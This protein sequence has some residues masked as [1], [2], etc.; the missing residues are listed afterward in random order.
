MQQRSNNKFSIF[1]FQ[2]SILLLLC[3][4]FAS[5]V[6]AQA[7]CPICVVAIGAG[8]GF[9]RWLGVDDLISSVWIGAVLL[10]LVIWTLYWIRKKNWDFKFSGIVT[11]LFYYLSTFI[12]LY[13]LKIVGH[14]LNTIFCIDKIVFGAFFGTVILALSLWLHSFLKKKN[15]DKSYF[16]YQRVVVP[17]FLLIL[18]SLAFY[19]LLIWRII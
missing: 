14:P 18:T 17:I 5:T 2:F 11:F 10:T 1:N 4:S 19:L 3:L 13:Y 12:P 9:S 8:L 6:L 7:V 15:N 16:P